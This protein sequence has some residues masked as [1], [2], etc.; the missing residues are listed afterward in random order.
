MR[1]SA[2]SAS[3]TSPMPPC[4]SRPQQSMSAAAR[5]RRGVVDVGLPPDAAPPGRGCEA[6]SRR[7]SR[8]P[9]PESCGRSVTI[10]GSTATS[11]D[12]PIAPDRGRIAFERLRQASAERAGR[13]A[14]SELTEPHRIVCIASIMPP[15]I[16]VRQQLLALCPQSALERVRT[17]LPVIS[18]ISGNREADEVSAT[19]RGATA[20]G[21]SR[22]SPSSALLVDREQPIVVQRLARDIQWSA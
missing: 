7:R 6:V 1:P 10:S 17:A 15:P 9:R 3:H 18:L 11:S 16:S 19:R 21:A 2:R 13:R 20:H 4:P 22:A 14:A 12:Q 8:S 5:A